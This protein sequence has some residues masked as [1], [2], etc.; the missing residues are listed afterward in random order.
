LQHCD[1]AHSSI[2][3]GNDGTDA[4]PGDGEGPVRRVSVGSFSIGATTVTNRAFGDFVRATRYVTDAEN[5][6]SSFVFYLQVPSE[7]RK[8]LRQ[9]VKDTPWWLPVADASWQR[10]EGPSSHIYKRLDHPVVQVS[11]NDAQ[12]YCAWAGAHL[13]TEAE[14]EC[15]ARGGREGSRFPWGDDLMEKGVPRC[16]V[17][18]GSLPNA[19]EEGWEP[20]PVA[21]AKGLPNGFGLINVCG[22]VWERCADWFSSAYHRET[23]MVNPLLA[24]PTGPRSM[25]GGSFLCH[26][27][28]CNRYRIGARSANTPESSSSN[29]GFRIAQ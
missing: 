5:V 18:R 23:A 20:E 19:P 3:T 1:K 25:R 2:R 8:H 4:V 22:N 10:P 15:T 6:G 28:Y 9:A 14:W 13:P 26:D 16:N 7:P 17:W 21:G 24:L 29:L 12:A 11:W 27:S